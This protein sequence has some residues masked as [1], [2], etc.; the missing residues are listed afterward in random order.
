[1]LVRRP[2]YA[3]KQAQQ[4]WSVCAELQRWDWL[5]HIRFVSDGETC[6]QGAQG[7]YDLVYHWVPYDSA[8]ISN[9]LDKRMKMISRM[10]RTGGHAFVIGPAQLGPQGLSK[11]LHI[12]W[13]E[14]VEQ[15]PTFRM[16]RTIL[17]QAR[18]RAGLTLFHMKKV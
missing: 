1:V 4:L 5:S 18:L 16:H 11:G 9:S 13:E 10:L 12:C 8:D 17:P 6:N 2:A 3:Q 7:F 15:L 14:L